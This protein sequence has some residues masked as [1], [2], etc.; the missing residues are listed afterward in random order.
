MSEVKISK[1]SISES[2]KI[3]LVKKYE[4]FPFG[5]AYECE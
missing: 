1:N 3:I 2:L 4:Y 5:K